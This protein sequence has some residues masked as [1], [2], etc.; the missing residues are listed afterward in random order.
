MANTLTEPLSYSRIATYNECPRKFELKYIQK[1]PELPHWYFSYGKSIHAVLERLPTCHVGEDGLL[2]AEQ[3][4]LFPTS[5]SQMLTESWLSQ[6]Y[7]NDREEER[8]KQLALRILTAF[9]PVF[10]CTWHQTLYAE[11]FFTTALDGIPFTGIVDRI[12]RVS[13]NVLRIVDYKSSKPRS[14]STLSSHRFQ[15]AL[16]AAALAQQDEFKGQ[17]FLLQTYY[18]R[19][20]LKAEL[21]EGTE[22][23]MDKSRQ[24]VTTTAHR[25]LTG[26]FQAK[27]GSSCF[28]CDY[29]TVCPVFRH[30]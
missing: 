12:D 29:R 7:A 28:S 8:K 10:Q 18:L 25:I 30:A 6:G 15:V 27:R 11:R 21:T 4:S 24:V 9:F 17:R 1:I 5:L 16:Y 26:D 2:Y 20:N 13:D 3:S 19:E 22:T 23:Y 14:A